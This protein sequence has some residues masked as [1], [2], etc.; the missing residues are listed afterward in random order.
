MNYKRNTPSH[1]LAESMPPGFTKIVDYIRGLK[2]LDKPDY[3]YIRWWINDIAQESGVIL[4]ESF[5]WQNEINKRTARNRLKSKSS[6]NLNVHVLN[7]KPIVDG[8]RLKRNNS[9]IKKRI[10]WDMVKPLSKSRVFK[11][12]TYS[13]SVAGPRIYKCS[14]AYLWKQP[15]SGEEEVKHLRSNFKLEPKRMGM[16]RFSSNSLLSY[17]KDQLKKDSI[18]KQSVD[19]SIPCEISDE[20]DGD[21][22]SYLNFQ[23]MLRNV[24]LKNERVQNVVAFQVHEMDLKKIGKG[25]IPQ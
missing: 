16:P 8:E 21:T 13:Q 24:N 12:W 4:D 5:W 19:M 25:G 22:E 14:S 1:V 7:N 10:T 9:H 18:L 15:N 11:V 3:D 20:E 23:A 17:K 6:K 2:F